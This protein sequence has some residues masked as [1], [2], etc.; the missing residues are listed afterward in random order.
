[1]GHADCLTPV[2]M[3]KRAILSKSKSADTSVVLFVSGG[4]AR[5]VEEN[6]P[7]RG[8][9]DLFFVVSDLLLSLFFSSFCALK[10]GLKLGLGYKARVQFISPQFLGGSS[11]PLCRLAQRRMIPKSLRVRRRCLHWFRHSGLL[12]TRVALP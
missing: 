1:M 10:I 8:D 11:E 6:K 7:P 2:M 5:D 12:L 9:S 3:R 4:R